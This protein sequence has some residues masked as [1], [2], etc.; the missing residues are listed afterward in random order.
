ML[1]KF[2]GTMRDKDRFINVT[3][4]SHLVEMQQ[5][6]DFTI[7]PTSTCCLF[8]VYAG[9]HLLFIMFFSG[10]VKILC[11]LYFFISRKQ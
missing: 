1:R 7:V 6:T 10:G 4:P 2:L 5:I 9:T 3:E 11:L 8:N